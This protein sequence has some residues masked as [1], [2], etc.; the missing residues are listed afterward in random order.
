MGE[1]LPVRMQLVIEFKLGKRAVVAPQ[2][3]RSLSHQSGV[4]CTLANVL[5]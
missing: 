2:A 5:V 3:Q 4:A 1:I